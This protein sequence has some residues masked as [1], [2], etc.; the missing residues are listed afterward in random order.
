MREFDQRLRALET[1]RAAGWR[2][3][4]RDGEAWLTSPGRQSIN[5]SALARTT[6]AVV[7][8]TGL[9]RKTITLLGG[10]TGGSF[11]LYY[12]KLPTANIAYNASAATVAQRIIDLDTA[13]DSSSVL[14][15]GSAGGPWTLIAPSG[16]LRADWT[17]L[18][19]GTDVSVQ[20]S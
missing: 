19:G 3:N 1:Q 2:L 9:W 11:I 12:N 8:Q 6:D 17:N 15:S 4:D 18:T 20:I 7:T 14:V 16:T 13:L 10:P 5:L